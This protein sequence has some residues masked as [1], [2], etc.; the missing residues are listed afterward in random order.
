VIVPRS[1]IHL[2]VA[3][4]TVALVASCGSERRD[5]QPMPRHLEQTTPAEP[6]SV[7]TV[8]AI[9]AGTRFIDAY[10]APSGR[11][12]RHDEGS[13]TVS[14][15]QAYAML[16]AAAIG[17]E[18]TFARVWTWTKNHMMRPDGLLAWHWRDGA[19]VDNQSAADADLDAAHALLLAAERFGEPAYGGEAST[20]ADAIYHHLTIPVDGGRL[21]VAGVWALDD[22]VW[23]PSY[24]SPLGFSLLY[25]SGDDARW[26]AVAATA[27]DLVDDLTSL[28]PHLPPDWARLT[29]S[30]P[31]P[32]GDPVRYSYD[33]V[34]ALWRFAL[35]CDPRGRQLAA[36]AWT[37]LA[38]VTD[39]G[40]TTPV[41]TY[42]LDGSP[43]TSGGHA[44]ATI[45]AAASA[46]AAGEPVASRQ[47]L[48]AA[49][50]QDHDDPSY[51]G[52]AL[53]ALGRLGIETDLLGRCP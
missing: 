27:R 38:V 31:V 33:A 13:D 16:I 25:R 32:Y 49:E 7:T 22:R 53:V 35:D 3:C 14:E 26:G 45:G 51:Y 12:V 37:F 2:V 50:V 47:L 24:F 36:R 42:G 21:L 28:P 5:H 1:L 17:D 43:L 9:Q 11:V 29:A 46:A 6:L 39:H 19:V 23:N 8:A 52:A 10:V 41:S 4:A 15:G 20:L 30:G 48:A 44:A 18:E 40:S 34:R